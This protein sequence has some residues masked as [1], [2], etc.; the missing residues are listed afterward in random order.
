MHSRAMGSKCLIFALC[1]ALATSCQNVLG[2][3]HIYTST[4]EVPANASRSL[5]APDGHGMLL[6]A[7][8]VLALSEGK[9]RR[10]LLQYSRTLTLGWSPDSKHFFVNDEASSDRTDLYVY[11]RRTGPKRALRSVILRADPELRRFA[12]A[13]SHMYISANRWIDAQTL[14]VEVSGH[15]D[16]PVQDFDRK[17]RVNID[18]KVTAL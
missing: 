8:G 13:G 1:V 9:S 12:H 7:N 3:D 6:A 5:P 16:S 4:M 11:D 15:T 14:D 18:G 17:F 10:D 2:Q